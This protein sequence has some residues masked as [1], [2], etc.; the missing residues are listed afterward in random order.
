LHSHHAFH[1]TL[2]VKLEWQLFIEKLCIALI[3]AVQQLMSVA[4]AQCCCSAA[5]LGAVLRRPTWPLVVPTR[6]SHS[7]TPIGLFDHRSTLLTVAIVILTIYLP[8]RWRAY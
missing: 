7:A 4:W 8:Q 1:V 3:Q 6:P 5:V 2:R